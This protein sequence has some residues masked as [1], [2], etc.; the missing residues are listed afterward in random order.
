MLLSLFF[1]SGYETQTDIVR[2]LQSNGF[3]TD[4]DFKHLKAYLNS[5]ISGRRSASEKLKEGLTKVLGNSLVLIILNNPAKSCN[6]I[7]QEYNPEFRL[8]TAY[9]ALKKYFL[10]TPPEEKKKICEDFKK[11]VEKHIRR[12]N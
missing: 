8:D 7:R 1:K 9:F 3:Y 4:S 2:A 12:H 11:Y 6:S 10:S 5:V